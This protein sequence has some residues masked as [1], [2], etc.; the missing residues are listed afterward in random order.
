MDI[1]GAIFDNQDQ[2]RETYRELQDSGIPGDRIGVVTKLEAPLQD[3]LEGQA[4]DQ[5]RLTGA[6]VGSS[7]IGSA[8][9]VAGAL[10]L[11]S[12]MVPV[13][14]PVLAGGTMAIIVGA[15]GAAGGWLAGGLAGKGMAEPHARYYQD[16]VEAGRI[17]MTVQADQPYAERAR[18]I[19]RTHGGREYN[20]K[21]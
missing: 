13:V 16:Q 7:T 12:V 6:I 15:A 2:V 9:L 10:A 21:R 4:R 8:G 19:L 1:F 5:G 18:A 3:E 20:A 17:L 14:G 11:A